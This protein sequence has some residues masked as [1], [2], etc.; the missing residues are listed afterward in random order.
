MGSHTRKEKSFSQLL[1]V[2]RV[3]MKQA[4]EERYNNKGAYIVLEAPDFS[5]PQFFEF[6]AIKPR[7]KAKFLILLLPVILIL[8]SCLILW[9][10][11][12]TIVCF[13]I[14]IVSTSGESC[15]A[16][17]QH[18]HWGSSMEVLIS[19]DFLSGYLILNEPN[20]C[21]SL[22]AGFSVLWFCECNWLRWRAWTRIRVGW[23]F[24]L[25]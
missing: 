20:G 19:S 1:N 5:K 13:L 9:S 25:Q 8:K 3:L 15:Y 12:V 17:C 4:T 7:P 6:D 2:W 16:L 24:C 11:T 18:L 22:C 23:C 21:M 14:Y 10:L